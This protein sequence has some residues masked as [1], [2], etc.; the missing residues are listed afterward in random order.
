MNSNCAWVR[1]NISWG[2]KQH[3]SAIMRATAQGSSHSAK[4]SK[5]LQAK[6]RKGKLA[7]LAW[8]QVGSNTSERPNG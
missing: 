8:Q 1:M 2:R 7:Q 4:G 3:Q 6:E 5:F